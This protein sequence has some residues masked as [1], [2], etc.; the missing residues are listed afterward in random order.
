MLKQPQQ[1]GTAHKAF[2][3]IEVLLV[4]AIVSIAAAMAAPRY[5]GAVSRYRADAAA[6]RIAADL[7]LMQSRAR[8]TG[9]SR[10]I[11]FDLTSNS[12]SVASETGLN[13]TGSYR[14]D[15][16][17]EPYYVSMTTLSFG[18]NA[19]LS[20]NGYGVPNSAGSIQ[21]RSGATTKAVSID[22]SS[23]VATIQ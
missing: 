18:G 15:L 12:Y 4:M 16:A 5:A 9:S 13:G 8:T 22:A 1:T 20:F 10:T 11:A 2:S 17:T 14:V 6:R 21:I 7:S 23:G 3:L 19:S